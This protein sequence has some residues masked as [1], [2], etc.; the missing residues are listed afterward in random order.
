MTSRLRHYVA[1]HQKHW[2]KFEF[3][4]TYVYNVQVHRTTKLRSFSPMI[5]PLRIGATATARP[6]PSDVSKIDIPLTYS[7]LLINRATLLK[8]MDEEDDKKAEVR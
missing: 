8:K 6:T 2:D 1:E 4:L 5:L 7:P 3:C